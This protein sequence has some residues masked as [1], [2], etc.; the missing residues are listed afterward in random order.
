MRNGGAIAGK[1]GSKIR[2]KAVDGHVAGKEAPRHA[3]PVADRGEIEGATQAPPGGGSE[4]GS[5][6]KSRIHGT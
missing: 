6:R 3:H 1:A 5:E 4:A 2:A